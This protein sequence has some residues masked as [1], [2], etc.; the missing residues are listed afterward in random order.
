MMVYL[1]LFRY[2]PQKEGRT[3]DPFL[4]EN[5]VVAHLVEHLV[6]NQKVV[7]SS[8]IY[9]TTGKPSEAQ[10]FRGL[11]VFPRSWTGNY[12]LL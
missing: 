6:R 9:S 7:G 8:P 10:R 11:F 2:T 1:F 5:G 12:H 3:N 4:I